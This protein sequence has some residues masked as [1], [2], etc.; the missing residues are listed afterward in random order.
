MYRLWC[1]LLLPLIFV[2]KPMHANESL[3]PTISVRKH[4]YGAFSSYGLEVFSNRTARFYGI[5]AKSSRVFHDFKISQDQYNQIVR[6]IDEAGLE[7]RDSGAILSSDKFHMDA[8]ATLVVIQAGKEK[9]SSFTAITA[10]YAKVILNLEEILQLKDLICPRS[11]FIDG[12]LTDLG[13]EYETQ[14]LRE[15]LKETQ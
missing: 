13:C 10:A 4:V 9:I 6:V 15:R 12:K 3:I 14:I 7:W 8:L 5:N 2:A 11:A 1:L